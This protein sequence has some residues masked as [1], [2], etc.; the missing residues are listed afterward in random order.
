MIK[1]YLDKLKPEEKRQI[2]YAFEHQ[3]S[4]RIFIDEKRFLGVNIRPS[5]NIKIIESV[6]VWS[7]GEV[8]D[9]KD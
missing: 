6:G 7:Y 5:K 4:Q 9:R 3:F 1:D 8:I 2:M